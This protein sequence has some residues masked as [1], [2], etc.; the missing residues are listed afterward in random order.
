MGSE[1]ATPDDWVVL[2]PTEIVP[3]PVVS[4]EAITQPTSALEVFAG[5]VALKTA[6]PIQENQNASSSSLFGSL[7]GYRYISQAYITRLSEQTQAEVNFF[8]GSDLYA[9]TL[10]EFSDPPLSAIEELRERLR[11]F[12]KMI[13]KNQE[14]EL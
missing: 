12:S 8:V 13:K 7:I 5:K 10:P 4:L 9:G 14:P 11:L 6:I 3:I 1:D 2:D